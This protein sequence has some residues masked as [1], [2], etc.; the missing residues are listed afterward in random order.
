MQ[1]ICFD[2]GYKFKFDKDKVHTSS[3]WRSARASDF[4]C[5]SRSPGEQWFYFQAGASGTVKFD[6]KSYRDH[7]YAIWGP[8]NSLSVAQNACGNT[9]APADCSYS[10]SAHE[11]ANVNGVQAGQYYTLLVTNFAKVTQELEVNS[12][13]VQIKCDAVAT[14]FE[15]VKQQWEAAGSPTEAMAGNPTAPPTLAPTTSPTTKAPTMPTYVGK[16]ECNPNNCADWDCAGWCECYDEMYIDLYEQ[17][18]ACKDDGDDS[19]SCDEIAGPSEP[20]WAVADVNDNSKY[21]AQEVRQENWD[22]SLTDGDDVSKCFNFC[23]G[24]DFCAFDAHVAGTVNGYR[25]CQRSNVCEQVVD[26]QD[27]RKYRIYTSS[28]TEPKPTFEIARFS[29][30][31]LDLTGGHA[32][33]HRTQE[34]FCES[35]GGRL[36]TY[37]EV[38]PTGE[39]GQPALSCTSAAD[40]SWVPYS[41]DANSYAYIS[42]DGHNGIICKDH[43]THHGNPNWG[44]KGDVYGSNVECMMP[45]NADTWVLLA[46]HDA[47]GGEFFSK[48]DAVN[49]GTY[50]S[51]SGKLILDLDQ[52]YDSFRSSADGKMTLKL[53]YPERNVKELEWKQSSSPLAQHGRVAGYEI[54]PGQTHDWNGSDDF[55]GVSRSSSASTLLDGQPEDGNWFYAIGAYESW[56]ESTM[57]PGPRGT[58]LTAHEDARVSHVEL[59][60]KYIPSA[61]RRKWTLLAK[62]DSSQGEFFPKTDAVYQGTYRSS[63]GNLILDLNQ[64]YDHFRGADGKLTLKLVYP[65]RNVKELEWKQTSSPL[66]GA[67]QVQGYEIEEGKTHDWNGSDDFK[68]MSRSSSASTLL[69]GQPENGNWYYAIG[70]YES[71]GGST[72][73][74]GPRGTGLAANEVA[75]VSHVELWVLN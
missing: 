30:K 38:C 46:K 71:W 21:C 22:C 23:E 53:V 65:E 41:K 49:Q 43:V 2:G 59:W 26:S 19:C 61:L 47:S 56:G 42:C 6:M 54:A 34:A 13:G 70:A 55:K 69:D 10:G 8:F 52:D 20:T 14:K 45:T 32:K 7:D 58:G 35:M 64:N 25:C 36:P 72:R 67:H 37:D 60:V 62:H 63:S 28:T 11:F 27:N 31:I 68:G 50:R 48:T 75:H 4:G 12:N 51:S 29:N 1:P 3:A 33:A 9:G 24:F 44:N 40:H 16:P 57:F 73:F 66:V 5:L 17:H 39:R 74:P 18:D 15:T